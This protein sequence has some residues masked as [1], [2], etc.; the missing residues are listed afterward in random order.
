MSDLDS[1]AM[2]LHNVLW[3]EGDPRPDTEPPS[4]LPVGAMPTC[5]CHS[6]AFKHCFAQT[7]QVESYC[8][9]AISFF[10][11]YLTKERA[12]KFLS[13]LPTVLIPCSL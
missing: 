6:A 2:P 1:G 7:S 10:E 13:N 3:N 4:S 9:K 11:T 8:K 12:M 5:N